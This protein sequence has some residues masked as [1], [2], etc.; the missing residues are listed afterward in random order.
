[1]NSV[2]HYASSRYVRFA[3]TMGVLA[4]LIAH[5]SVPTEVIPVLGTVLRYGWVAF[6]AVA[7]LSVQLAMKLIAL[8]DEKSFTP[9]QRHKLSDIVDERLRYLW[10]LA[11]VSVLAML[12]CVVA[13]TENSPAKM[14]HASIVVAVVFTVWTALLALRLWRLLQEIKE[15]L[16][17]LHQ[18][19][20]KE[21]L[22]LALLE[23]IKA[24]ATEREISVPEPVQLEFPGGERDAP[25]VGA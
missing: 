2:R 21:D 19:R 4:G 7:A 20:E 23:E 1:M 22:R 25:R 12:A 18:R 16:W 10:D 24:S 11:I 13:G 5:L 15:F 14:A 3:M 17:Y 9:Q 6:G 8:G